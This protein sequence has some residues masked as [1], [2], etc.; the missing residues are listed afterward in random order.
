VGMWILYI[1]PLFARPRAELVEVVRLNMCSTHAYQGRAFAA[2]ALR[3]LARPDTG[4]LPMQHLVDRQNRGLVI[5]AVVFL[6][7]P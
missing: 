5:L 4:N 1:F 3:V 2:E 6:S 7:S